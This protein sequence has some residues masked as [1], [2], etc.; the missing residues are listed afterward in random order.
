MGQCNGVMGFIF[1]H[2]YKPVITKGI[3]VGKVKVNGISEEG[4]LE[5]IEKCRDETYS[6]LYCSRCGEIKSR[7][8]D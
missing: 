5:M 6:G 1:G 8:G 2:K 7:E 3:P 4:Y